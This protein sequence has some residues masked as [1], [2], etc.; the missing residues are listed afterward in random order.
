[1]LRC[2]ILLIFTLSTHANNFINDNE[3]ASKRLGYI[4]GENIRSNKINLDLEAFLSGLE[5]DD[6]KLEI[7]SED[8]YF[9][10]LENLKNFILI[11]KQN[12]N[13][14]IANRFLEENK[15]RP[16]VIEI[17]P[18]KIQYESI[19]KGSGDEITPDNTPLIKYTCSTLDNKILFKTSEPQVVSPDN[20]ILG[21]SKGLIGMKEGEKRVIYIHPDFGDQNQDTPFLIKLEVE[22]LKS[23]NS[24]KI[25]KSL[26]SNIVKYIR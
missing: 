12:L 25:S 14:K 9:E 17:I 2:A 13:L 8:S 18:G 3:I 11:E 16:N 20:L 4:I 5:N 21:F 26:I 24:S 22:V 10:I 15:K 23:Q 7:S 6:E 19:I 1:M